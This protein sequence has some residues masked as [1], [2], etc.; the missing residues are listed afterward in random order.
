M[1]VCARM[2]VIPK[3]RCILPR[4]RGNGVKAHYAPR[5]L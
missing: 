3:A 1:E 4:G 5:K 2:W